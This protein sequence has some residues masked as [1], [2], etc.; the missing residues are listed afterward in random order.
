MYEHKRFADVLKADSSTNGQLLDISQV[1]LIGRVE[2]WNC[3]TAIDSQWVKITSHLHKV[4]MLPQM[5][6]PEIEHI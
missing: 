5:Y 1:S 2:W 3:Y 6:V 4:N